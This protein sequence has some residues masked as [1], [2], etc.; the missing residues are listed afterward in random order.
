MKKISIYKL[1]ESMLNPFE[2]EE[3]AMP[4]Q[5]KVAPPDFQKQIIN[6]YTKAGWDAAVSGRP[7]ILQPEPDAR[8]FE[9]IAM[10]AYQQAFAAGNSMKR[11]T[12]GG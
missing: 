6:K 12:A 8:G 2:D 3:T 11:K 9:E 7:P 10:R 5:S 1:I 4:N